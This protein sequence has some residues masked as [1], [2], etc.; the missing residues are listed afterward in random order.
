MIGANSVALMGV[1]VPGELADV[2]GADYSLAIGKGTTQIGANIIMSDNVELNVSAGQTAVV[3]PLGQQIAEPVH[4][5]N[6]SATATTALVFV[7]SGHTINGSLNGSLSVPQNK[8]AILWQYKN[9]FWTGI[10]SN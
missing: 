9:K 1:G 10:V 2:I 7:P 5:V 6:T 8:G 3:Q 4:L